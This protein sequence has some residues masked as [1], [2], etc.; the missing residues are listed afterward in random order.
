MGWFRYCAVVGVVHALLLG[1]VG[2]GP[3]YAQSGATAAI[4]GTVTDGR[5]VPVVGASVELSD[6][7]MGLRAAARSDAAGRFH[8][9]GL[10]PGGPYTFVVTRLGSA[11]YGRRESQVRAR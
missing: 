10:R 5:G 4:L 11:R 8:L 9:A 7:A 3:L 6:P 2:A 1:G